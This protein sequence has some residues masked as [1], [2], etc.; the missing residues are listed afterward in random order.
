M[1]IVGKGS[2]EE[3]GGTETNTGTTRNNYKW[4]EPIRLM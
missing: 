4:E 1:C 3:G 2:E